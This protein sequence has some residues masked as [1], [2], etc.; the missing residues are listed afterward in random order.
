[1]RTVALTNRNK[2]V[3]L[4]WR[5]CLSPCP[6]LETS[7]LLCQHCRLCCS[8]GSVTW[9]TDL[10]KFVCLLKRERLW[11]NILHVSLGKNSGS[12]THSKWQKPSDGAEWKEK[13]SEVRAHLRDRGKPRQAL[14]H[15]G[16]WSKGATGEG[17]LMV[18]QSHLLLQLTFFLFCFLQCT[19]VVVISQ[20]FI[21]L[22]AA[23]MIQLG[24]RIAFL[25]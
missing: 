7:P 8:Q 21:Y 9:D 6:Y 25:L 19:S 23:V 2:Q 16:E 3:W 10:Q 4:L 24:R 13:R 17:L 1:M 22:I 20:V 5:H 12:H 14:C 15:G 18:Q 11:S